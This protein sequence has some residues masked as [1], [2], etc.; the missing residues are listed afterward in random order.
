MHRHHRGGVSAFA[1]GGR[2]ASTDALRAFTLIEL[3]VVVAIIS[4]L[5][6]ILFPVFAQ[7]REKARQAACLSNCKQ[8]GAALY[9]YVQDYDEVLPIGAATLFPV[10][11]GWT[12]HRWY[13]LIEPYLK[14]R[15]TT[16]YFAAGGVY[17]C[18]SKPDF[19]TR[20]GAYG[21]NGNLIY[22]MFNGDLY[23]QEKGAR[24]DSLADIPDVAGTFLVAE[25][26]WLDR[27]TTGGG[28]AGNLAA[29][30]NDCTQW[31]SELLQTATTDFQ[32]TAPGPWSGP[33]Y[34]YGNPADEN[35]TRRPVPRHNGGLNV[36]YCDGHARWSR[37]ERF[38]GVTPVRPRGWPYGDS[39]NSWDNR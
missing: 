33:G 12:N 28:F 24:P 37:I 20:A 3:L 21:I 26:A 1:P 8:I 27:R 4:V 29:V 9:Q 38:L 14:T 34:Q 18:P 17:T 16:T 25:A 22:A 35:D 15:G 31:G 19:V 23:P 6:A 39:N 30:N 7:A 32:A 36:I 5:A 11:P 2:P 13:N 10:P